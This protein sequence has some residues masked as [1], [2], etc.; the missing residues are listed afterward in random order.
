[1]L[2][3]YLPFA[4]AGFAL[5]TALMIADALSCSASAVNWI[6]PTGT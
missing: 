1:M 2:R 5:R 4:A 3:T 6:L